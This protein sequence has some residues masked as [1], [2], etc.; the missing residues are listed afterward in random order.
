M[1]AT[2]RFGIAALAGAG[3]LLAGT[4]GWRLTSHDDAT[5][6]PTASTT[7]TA[8]PVS[9]LRDAVRRNPNNADAW[10]AL[11]DAQA[12]TN[13]FGSAVPSFRRATTLAPERALPWSALGEALVK[14]DPRD[15]FPA[16][17]LDAF[18]RA[19]AIDPKD[20][21]A[22]YFLGVRRDLDGDHKGAIDAWFAIL[23]DSPPG[24]PWVAD[25][26]RTIEQVAQINKI[27]VA[28]RLAALPTPA[29][30]DALGTTAGSAIPGPTAEQMQSAQSLTP[31]QQQAMIAGM[32]D[33]LEARLAKEKTNVDGW[34]MLMR[35]RIQLR[36][37]DK[38][39]AA[40]RAALAANP[41]AAAR[42]NAE[43]ATLGIPAS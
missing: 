14:A 29:P 35:S 21:R 19:A 4:I 36:E 5:P 26:R 23:K 8:D 9:E 43:A 38:A 20:P 17:A 2:S 32:V 37:P 3:V 13:D 6:A 24:A 41:G 34:V 40:L 7:P 30:H 28:K 16:A 39:K 10:M 11:G 27:D 42:L 22:R 15:P 33:Q 1:A 18:K 31:S 12:A 25:I